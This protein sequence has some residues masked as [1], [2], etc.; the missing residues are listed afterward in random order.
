MEGKDC[1]VVTTLLAVIAKLVSYCKENCDGDYYIIPLVNPDG[2]EYA[3][4]V[5]SRWLKSRQPFESY[6]LPIRSFTHNSSVNDFQ[7]KT[8]YGVRLDFNYPPNSTFY[9]GGS[10]DP[11]SETYRGPKPAH[12][13]EIQAVMA[14]KKSLPN[15]QLGITFLGVNVVYSSSYDKLFFPYAHKRRVHRVPEYKQYKH[16]ASA[17]YYAVKKYDDYDVYF[18]ISYDFP[19]GGTSMDYWYSAQPS[20]SSFIWALK[21]YPKSASTISVRANRVIAGINGMITKKNEIVL[22]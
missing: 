20:C 18:Y 9:I 7:T 8:C 16:L 5:D 13:P 14:L 1:H 6:S 17:C 19:H 12:A 4:K 10:S 11:C 2:Y 21:P 3:R 15:L 22:P